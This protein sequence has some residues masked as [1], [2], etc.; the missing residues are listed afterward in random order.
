MKKIIVLL[1]FA[2]SF[3]FFWSCSTLT[4]RYIHSPASHTP[5]YLKNKGDS[6]VS[7]NLAFSV[8]E[9]LNNSFLFPDNKT[10]SSTI[11]VDVN[12]AYAFTDWLMM[13]A[14]G[15]YKHET[16][17]NNT[18]DILDTWTD[19]K[20]T[21]ARK[22]FDVGIGLLI[23]ITQTRDILFNPIIGI[24]FGKT[25]SEMFNISDSISDNR[26]FYLNGNTK[27]YYLSPNFNFELSKNQKISISPRF[28]LLKFDNI[29]NSCPQQ[30]IDRLNLN[31]LEKNHFFFSPSL[32]YQMGFDNIDWLKL[33]VGLS[34]ST[35]MNNDDNFMYLKTRAFQLSSGIS[36]YF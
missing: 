2:V 23:P 30:I 10:T 4:P 14:G 18:N 35:R 9:H 22:A 24:N 33:D 12:T 1:A 28:S 29:E 27:E 6:K 26:R 21:Y 11:G 25:S 17:I 16:D 7:A 15:Y 8:E 36:V 32:F 31:A 13:T 19:S 20:T 34:F 5:A 3:V